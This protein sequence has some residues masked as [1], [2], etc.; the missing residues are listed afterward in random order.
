MEYIKEIAPIITAITLAYNVWQT[1]TVKKN[2]GALEQNTNSK[3]DQLLTVTAKA[4]LAEGKAVG[5]EQGRNE[6]KV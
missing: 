2:V 1:W 6:E 4:A 5:L 3:M